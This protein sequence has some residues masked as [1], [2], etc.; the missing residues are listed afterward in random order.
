MG[1]SKNSGVVLLLVAGALTMGTIRAQNPAQNP[2]R[3]ADSA[4]APPPLP[5]DIYADSRTRLPLATVD[6]DGNPI[7]MPKSKLPVGI[8]QPGVSAWSPQ[9][10]KAMRPYV[11]Y[12][13]YE[14][15]LSNRQLEIAILEVSREMDSQYLWTQY[16]EHGHNPS[17]PRHIEQSTIDII[18]YEKP[19][20]GLDEKE[21]A[22]IEFGRETFG[23]RL[24]SPKTFAELL[25]LFGR[26]GTIDL[27][28][29]MSGYSGATAELVAF[30]N[31]LRADQKPLLPPIAHPRNPARFTAAAA[32]PLPADVYPESRNR[33]PLPKR[34]DMD[35]YG[36]KVFDEQTRGKPRPNG[37]VPD[38]FLPT[39][40]PQASVLLWDPKLAALRGPISHY[41]KYE[42]GLPPRLLEIAVLVTAYEMDCQYEWTQWEMFARNPADPRHLE[43]STIDI[44]KYNKPIAALGEKEAAIIQFGRETFGRRKLS[45]ETFAKV[46][47][48]FGR[49]GTVDLLEL[50]A[51]YS[52]TAGQLTA[53]DEQLQPGQKPLLPPHETSAS[54]QRI[55]RQNNNVASP[56]PMPVSLK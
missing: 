25:N 45:S 6:A 7:V 38:G 21:A 48:L 10:A 50:M 44:I 19:L 15:G 11:D 55:P 1:A 24:L 41:L 36:K 30:D 43:Q 46:L 14:I 4:A 47:G 2:P 51:S 34:E 5:K 56:Q 26:K 29:M 37:E 54:A 20:T 31:Q 27:I 8:E 3:P 16:E 40:T 23:Q 12:I 52:G 13:K 49:K 33:F 35:D 53:I 28:E 39:G 32:N 9:Y 17:D 22:I 42:T 18:K